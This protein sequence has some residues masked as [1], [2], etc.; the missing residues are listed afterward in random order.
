MEAT[1]TKYPHMLILDGECL[2]NCVCILH[3]LPTLEMLYNYFPNNF[4]VSYFFKFKAGL[5]VDFIQ[6]QKIL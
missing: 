2:C 4:N 5:L 1:V 3:I 6:S